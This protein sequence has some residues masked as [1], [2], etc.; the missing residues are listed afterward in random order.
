MLTR[1]THFFFLFLVILFS[2]LSVHA[3]VA[4]R[5]LQK[6]IAAVANAHAATVGVTIQNAEGTE[7][8]GV[9]GDHHFAMQSVYKFHLALALLH[10]VD[11]GKLQLEQVVTLR[12]EQI[13][14]DTHS[15]M[16]DAYPDQDIT[17][18]IKELLRYTV[19]LSDNNACDALFQLAGGTKAVNEYIHSLQVEDVSVAAT[20][21]EMKKDGTVQFTNWSTPRAA[22]WLLWLYDRASILS[23]AS[24]D[25]LWELM[26]ASVKSDRLKGKLPAHASVAHK[27]GTSGRDQEGIRAAFN[28]IGIVTLPDGSRFYISVFINNSKEPDEVNA[29][30]IAD[31]TRLYYDFYS[32][33]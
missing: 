15:P 7:S 28:D 11:D 29:G 1:Q 16:R 17:I 26:M 6:K 25:Y 30:I 3:Q 19:S 21:G 22:T 32:G 18:S 5:G 24:H 23:T 9:N 31:I 10:L 13:D 2:T 8:F 27:P 14:T 4:R 20:E 12:K 33:K